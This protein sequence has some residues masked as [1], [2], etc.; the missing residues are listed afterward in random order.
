M[1]AGL[2]DNTKQIHTGGI[3]INKI[4]GKLNDM[5]LSGSLKHV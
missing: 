2:N 4:S 5:V 3:V 1:G